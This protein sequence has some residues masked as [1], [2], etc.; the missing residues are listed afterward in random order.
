VN[1]GKDGGTTPHAHAKNFAASVKESAPGVF[2]LSL[3]DAQIRLLRSGPQ[4][5]FVVNRANQYQ[6]YQQMI[7]QADVKKQGFVELSDLQGPQYQIVRLL[8]PYVDWNRDGKLTEQEVKNYMEL[9]TA[10]LDCPISMTI[11]DQGRALFQLLD[12]NRDGRLSQ[13]E[14]LSAWT[15]L[16][17][18]DKEKTGFIAKTDLA[19]QFQI[20][21]Q[22]GFTNNLGGF[23]PVFAPGNM[24]PPVLPAALPKGTPSWFSK[25]DTNGD[26]DISLAEFLGSR[27][28]FDRID[29]DRDGL[30]SP[31]E[32]IRYDALV[33][34]KK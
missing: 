5:S 19:R 20:S 34:G 14:L 27:E 9:Q 23:S 26:G 28:E 1:L 32:A 22:R 13:R 15:R 30:I 2:E 33:R 24:N 4:T 25:M 21:V 10:A 12:A 8:F 17:P 29:T 11:A 7:R 16:A 6:F 31:E 18:F 3:G